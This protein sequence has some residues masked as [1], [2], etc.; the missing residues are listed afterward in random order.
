MV[1]N[2]VYQY[3]YVRLFVWIIWRITNNGFRVL[4]MML[5]YTSVLQRYYIQYMSGFD[6]SLLKEIIQ[7]GQK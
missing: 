7:V 4:A 3:V 6:N 1:N 2:H 5:K